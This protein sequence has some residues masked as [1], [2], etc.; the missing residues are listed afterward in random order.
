MRRSF[1]PRLRDRVPDV[2]QLVN[3][4]AR[5][6]MRDAAGGG[7]IAETRRSRAGLVVAGRPAATRRRGA[8]LLGR[9]GE[10]IRLRR[11]QR[12]ASPTDAR[13][14]PTGSLQVKQ[15]RRSL[16]D[17]STEAKCSAAMGPH[18]ARLLPPTGENGRGGAVTISR[19]RA[20][21]LLR[22]RAARRR[23]LPPRGPDCGRSSFAQ[24]REQAIVDFPLL[25]NRPRGQR[26]DKLQHRQR[27]GLRRVQKD[28]R[29]GAAASV[30]DRHRDARAHATHEAP[31]RCQPQA[32]GVKTWAIDFGES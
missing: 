10:Q 27:L 21:T 26:A 4:S 22:E 9:E 11:A 30:P 18:H 3:S 1:A 32:D 17:S 16:P 25:V 2:R 20:A 19:Y 15:T 6:P 28:F 14:R 13:T 29:G 31:P 24:A 8:S 7:G 23:L 12:P 5:S